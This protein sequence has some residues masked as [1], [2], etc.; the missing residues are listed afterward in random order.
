MNLSLSL[1]T[2]PAPGFFTEA[3]SS[4]SQQSKTLSLCQARGRRTNLVASTV[5]CA[6]HLRTRVGIARAAQVSCVISHII[7]GVSGVILL[8]VVHPIFLINKCKFRPAPRGDCDGYPLSWPPKELREFQATSGLFLVDSGVLLDKCLTHL[9]R[10]RFA[11]CKTR[12]LL[13]QVGDATAHHHHTELQV[14]KGR[15]LFVLG[16]KARVPCFLRLPAPRC[17]TDFHLHATAP[18]WQSR[19]FQFMRLR[20]PLRSS[21]HR[22]PRQ[23]LAPQVRGAIQLTESSRR[24]WSLTSFSSLA[25]ASYLPFTTEYHCSQVDLWSAAQC[26]DLAGHCHVTAATLALPSHERVR[27]LFHAAQNRSKR[28]AEH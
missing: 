23:L 20:T 28:G 19:V 4:K 17:R 18:S 8:F 11:G 1:C 21:I 14:F 2:S 6:P 16:K 10:E 5:A 27:N 7:V 12:E 3:T 9:T 26:V 24:S 22:P 15:Q 25:Y 13:L